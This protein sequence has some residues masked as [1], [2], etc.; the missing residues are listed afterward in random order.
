MGRR[1]QGS[2]VAAKNIRD[3]SLC[4]NVQHGIDAGRPNH[5]HLFVTAFG[6][7]PGRCQYIGDNNI[8]VARGRRIVIDIRHLGE[9]AE[10]FDLGVKI[11]TGTSFAYRHT[12]IEE[13][14][15]S[16]GLAREEL[17]HDDRVSTNLKA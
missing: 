11:R 3:F 12:L 13:P 17:P 2:A 6:N 5:I 14:H 9:I 4:A 8:P 1:Q 10:G 15:D 7:R 16:V